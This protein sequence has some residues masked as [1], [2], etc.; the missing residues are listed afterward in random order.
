VDISG[1]TEASSKISSADVSEEIIR[2]LAN[3][4]AS[5]PSGISRQTRL[6]D[7]LSFDST[8][9]LEFLMEL[10]DT[11]GV[12]FDPFTL[13]PEDFETVGALLDYV[14]GQRGA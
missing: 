8:T 9:V 11:L 2:I 3:M 12:E 7:D 10:E 6:F 1:N 4:S 13:T 14:T 5:E